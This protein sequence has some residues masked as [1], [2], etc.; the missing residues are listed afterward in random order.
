MNHN[1]NFQN[2]STSPEQQILQDIEQRVTSSHPT[3]W[4][5]N[6]SCL[7]LGRG[8][9]TLTVFVD[10]CAGYSTIRLESSQKNGSSEEESISIQKNFPVSGSALL[11]LNTSMVRILQSA[12][13]KNGMLT[14]FENALSLNSKGAS[15]LADLATGTRDI[16]S[17]AWDYSVNTDC[18][19]VGINLF[20]DIDGCRVMIEANEA[21]YADGYRLSVNPASLM[22]PS[23]GSQASA[24]NA[25][26]ARHA[27]FASEVSEKQ[28]AD[29]FA[30]VLERVPEAKDWLSE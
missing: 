28:L 29:L 21:Y 19:P 30:S 2:Y 3:D 6:G 7:E 14:E 5:L 10:V 8:E 15:L 24:K 22:E 18:V 4:H 25:W 12:L 17:S 1:T 9:E 26:I 27:V 11:S 23:D 20:A 16:S 13:E